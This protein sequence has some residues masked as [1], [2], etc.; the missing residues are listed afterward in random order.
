VETTLYFDIDNRGIIPRI[1]PRDDNIFNSRAGCN[2]ISVA[3]GNVIAY[4]EVANPP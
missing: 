4:T 2:R 1:I 3:S